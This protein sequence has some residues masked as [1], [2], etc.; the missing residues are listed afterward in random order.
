MLAPIKFWERYL[1]FEGVLSVEH[2]CLML[3]DFAIPALVKWHI[4][5][6]IFEYKA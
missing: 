3:L 6:A 2:T 4:S 5:V 1:I